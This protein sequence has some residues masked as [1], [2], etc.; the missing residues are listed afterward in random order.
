[1][2]AQTISIR[3]HGLVEALNERAVKVKTKGAKTSFRITNGSRYYR[4]L[5]ETG[6]ALPTAHAFIDHATGDVYKAAALGIPAKGVR[7]NLLDNDNYATLL[8]VA[9]VEGTY[10]RLK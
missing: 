5:K 2:S 3:V 4:I 8:K 9:D 6:A 10:L 1:M 7:F